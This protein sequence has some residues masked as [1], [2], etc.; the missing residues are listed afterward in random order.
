M[1]RWLGALCIRRTRTRTRM[2][3]ADA[4][5]V[6]SAVSVLTCD[7]WY[8]NHD[9][10]SLLLFWLS[11]G[12][13]WLFLTVFDDW[14]TVPKQSKPLVYQSS[15]VYH[16][17]T[18]SIPTVYQ[19][20]KTVKRQSKQQKWPSVCQLSHVYHD[21]T[22]TV[23]IVKNWYRLVFHCNCVCIS[24]RLWD[25]EHQIMPWH[26]NLSH[27]SSRSLKIVPFESL[28]IGLRFT[29]AFH[30]PSNYGRILYHFWDKARYWSKIAIF[31]T[32]AFDAP[33]GG[34]RRNCRKVW[35]GKT[36]T[37]WL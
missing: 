13:F 11:F 17:C 32:R 6:Y 1:T 19:S 24:Y 36:R 33:L 23:L 28:H 25:T 37:M 4:D 2:A 26:W 20:S 35:H 10:W 30:R 29:I 31:H 34:S 5:F 7:D 15:Q 3:D 8:T 16:D 21:C 12:C 18:N 27:D 22:N 9:Q 14:Y